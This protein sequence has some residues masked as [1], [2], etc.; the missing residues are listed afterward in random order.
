MV[1]LHN[2][3]T[4]SI[5]ICIFQ[6]GGFQVSWPAHVFGGIRSL[7]SQYLYQGCPSTYLIWC[8][9]CLP[10]EW[11]LKGDVRSS[12]SDRH[13]TL[14]LSTPFSPGTITSLIRRKMEVDFRG[15][16][17]GIFGN[18]FPLNTCTILTRAMYAFLRICKCFGW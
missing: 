5:L 15:T 18:A 13:L 3:S 10:T 16:G 1:A 11:E 2:S 14:P 4:V 8:D 12:V 7:Y 6:S 17:F 9:C